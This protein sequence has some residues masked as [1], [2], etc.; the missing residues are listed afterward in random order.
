MTEDGGTAAG[1]QGCHLVRMRTC[2]RANEIDAPVELSETAVVQTR[3]GLSGRNP[4]GEELSVVDRSVLPA[5][6]AQDQGIDG[7]AGELTT[8]TVVNPPLNADAPT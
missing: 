8:Y 6:Q 5:R 2:S 1:E 4:G 3:G 7:S